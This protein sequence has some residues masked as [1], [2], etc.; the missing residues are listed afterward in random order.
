MSG[1][2]SAGKVPGRAAAA[3]VSAGRLALHVLERWLGDGQSFFDC[4]DGFL[5]A[6]EVSSRLAA[7]VAAATDPGGGLAA[8]A[9]CSLGLGLPCAAFFVLAASSGV[10]YPRL[11]SDFFCPVGPVSLF[12]LWLGL[13]DGSLRLLH[14]PG[15][16]RPFSLPQPFLSDLGFYSV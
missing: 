6:D 11:A 13:Q 4:Q 3:S 9:V 5:R 14:L 1:V 12:H 7:G 16:R 8:A 10:G 15:G 2:W